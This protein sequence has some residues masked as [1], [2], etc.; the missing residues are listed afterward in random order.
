MSIYDPLGH[1]IQNN[2]IAEIYIESSVDALTYVRYRNRDRGLELLNEQPFESSHDVEEMLE[3]WKGEFLFGEPLADG[4]IIHVIEPPISPDQTTIIIRKPE[5]KQIYTLRDFVDD[6]AA[7]LLTYALQSGANILIVGEASSGKTSLVKAFSR[8]LPPRMLIQ[9]LNNSAEKL[10]PHPY[11]L[12]F[13][14]DEHTINDFFTVPSDAIII[15]H[16]LDDRSLINI[17][18]N[19]SSGRTHSL[20][21]IE[22]VDLKSMIA[23]IETLPQRT[24]IDMPLRTIRSHLARAFDLILHIQ[25][26]KDVVSI[27]QIVEPEFRNKHLILNPIQFA[28]QPRNN[29]DA[30]AIV[31]HPRIASLIEQN[32]PNPQVQQMMKSLFGEVM[33]SS[34]SIFEQITKRSQQF[35]GRGVKNKQETTLNKDKLDIPSAYFKSFD[36]QNPPSIT[37]AALR[38]EDEYARVMRQAKRVADA[39]REKLTQEDIDSLSWGELN[40]LITAQIQHIK[41]PSK[42]SD[43]VSKRLIIATMMRLLGDLKAL[44]KHPEVLAFFILAPNCILMNLNNK[45]VLSDIRYP[46]EQALLNALQLLL[47]EDEINLTIHE[48]VQLYRLKNGDRIRIFQ[49]PLTLHQYI[50]YEKYNFSLLSADDLVGQDY[51]SAH[52]AGLINIIMRLGFNVLVSGLPT[53][54]RVNFIN[55]FSEHIPNDNRI[56]T[57]ENL[58]TLALRQEHVVSL[59]LNNHSRLSIQDILNAAIDLRPDVIITDD[60]N[61]AESFDLIELM[62]FSDLRVIT[63]VI[64][65]NSLDALNRLETLALLSDMPIPVELIQKR[66]CTGLDFIVHLDRGDDNSD[67]VAEIIEVQTSPNGLVELVP[68]IRFDNASKNWKPTGTVPLR[69]IEILQDGI[70][71]KPE[72]FGYDSTNSRSLNQF[73]R[74]LDLI[75]EQRG[76]EPDI[77]RRMQIMNQKMLEDVS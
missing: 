64:A 34:G 55:V 12:Q 24:G 61:G 45:L 3:H 72:L 10:C 13:L 30:K 69:I 58:A 37:P 54:D 21:T 50:L 65:N 53:T 41:S 27:R 49:A 8:Y 57:V 52:A 68:I 48:P 6:R 36:L 39:I 28:T 76:L 51:L 4:N 31:A 62:N 1:L 25:I 15:D 22:A 70:G 14:A 33:G 60:L 73:E 56:V 35:L 16:L 42:D 32:N 43:T 19:I 47:N 2:N 20:L 5:P 75:V 38:K 17:L 29:P 18:V 26:E 63:S 66:I 67:R 7:C 71:I 11:Q 59:E 77:Y 74:Q 44:L 23:R 40:Q 9:T 46:S